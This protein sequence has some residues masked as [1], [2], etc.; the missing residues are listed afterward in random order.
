[1]SGIKVTPEQLNAL[2][3]SVARGSGDIE[4]TLSTLRSQVAPLVGGDWAGAASAQFNALYE[5]WARS[6]KDLNDALQGISGL[7]GR[8]ATSY[9]TAEG[10][11]A[12]SFR[13]Q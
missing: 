6:A 4:G 2:S 1:M 10:E 12:S 3:A 7:L 11:I 13:Q 8:A 5:Q 9:A